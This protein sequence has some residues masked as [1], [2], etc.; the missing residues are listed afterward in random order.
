MVERGRGDLDLPTL[1]PLAMYGN[2]RLKDLVLLCHHRLDIGHAEI[3]SVL[4]G[5]AYRGSQV[6]GQL[7]LAGAELKAEPCQV[8]PRLQ[9]AY[10]LYAERLAFPASG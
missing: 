1:L 9:V 10:I 4:N 7:H 2:H 3:A 5:A 8:I 6:P